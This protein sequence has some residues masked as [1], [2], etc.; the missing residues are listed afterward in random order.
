ML[1]RQSV[2]P[3]KSEMLSGLIEARDLRMFLDV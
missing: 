2:R 1:T 3:E